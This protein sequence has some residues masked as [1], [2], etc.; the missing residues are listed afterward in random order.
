[1]SVP[2]RHKPRRFLPE[3]IETSSRSSKAPAGRT[4]VPE[5]KP[6]TPA[7]NSLGER[8]HARR[9]FVPQ[10]METERRSFRRQTLPDSSSQESSPRSSGSIYDDTFP[11]SGSRMPSESRFSYSNLLKRQETRRHS[12]RVPDLPAIPSSCSEASDE[13]GHS[14]PPTIPRRRRPELVT[15]NSST[16]PSRR[17]SCDEQFADYLLSLEAAR[18]AEMQLQEQAL[19]AF[20]NE[21]V[22]QP[23][24]HFAIDREEEES[25]PEDQIMLG[26]DDQ[27]RYRRAS[28]ADLS[29]ELDYMR[30]HKEEA[31][32]RD[33]AMAGTKGTR[34]SHT[35]LPTSL[36]P[37]AGG[38]RYLGNNRRYQDAAQ[39]KHLRSP[40]MLGGDLVFPQSL[41]PQTSI[42]EPNNDQD[43]NHGSRR[44]SGLWHASSRHGDSSDDNGLWMGTCKVNGHGRNSRD[45]VSGRTRP[46]SLRYAE[47]V[48]GPYT[49]TNTVPSKFEA[50]PVPVSNAAQDKGS[51]KAGVDLSTEFD[52]AFV[53]QIYNYLSLGYPCVARYYDYELSKVS[54][55]PV[56]DLRRD[57][58][59]TDAKGYVGV[60][61]G[62]ATSGDIERS[63]CMRWKALRIYIHQ[64]ARQHPTVTECDSNF[65]TWG[66]RERRGSWAG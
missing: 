11:D 15:S 8:H 44:S 46:S 17:E 12:F 16:G 1:M 32:M 31:E 66:V 28:S 13:S 6:P 30:Q 38:G 53:T 43:H 58:L 25:S 39:M 48:D 51:G 49:P 57:D 23:V 18:A 56:S 59:H 54:G 4:A 35:A 14:P 27:I 41:S 26:T 7:E 55:I 33:R 36:A 9:R 34:L 24:D 50:Q 5:T 40:P 3:P 20:P 52:D 19:A 62:S 21:Q 22:H 64:W 45:S 47:D 10:L 65:E 42:C 61:K 60:T 2:P 29:W 37:E 63:V